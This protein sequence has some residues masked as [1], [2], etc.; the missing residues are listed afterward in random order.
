[1][2]AQRRSFD[3]Q[4]ADNLVNWLCFLFGCR[5]VADPEAPEISSNDP[6][7]VNPRAMVCGRCGQHWIVADAR[8]AAGTEGEKGDDSHGVSR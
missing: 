4:G 6:T 8:P 2:G 1:M 3:R 7:I 5:R